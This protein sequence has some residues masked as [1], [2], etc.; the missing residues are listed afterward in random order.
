MNTFLNTPPCEC[1]I[2]SATPIFGTRKLS[3]THCFYYFIANRKVGNRKKHNTKTLQHTGLLKLMR[4]YTA[5]SEKSITT[6][7]SLILH[8]LHTTVNTLTEHKTSDM[9]P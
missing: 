9:S 6:E 3:R 4:M 1:E 2:P 5:N 8:C 7:Y